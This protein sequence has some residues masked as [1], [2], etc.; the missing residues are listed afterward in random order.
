[1]K[2]IHEFFYRS[3]R[4]F[5]NIIVK[6]PKICM[7]AVIVS[8]SVW[9]IVDSAVFQS[10]GSYYDETMYGVMGLSD[11]FLNWF[12]W[13]VIGTACGLLTYVITKLV[14]SYKVLVIANLEKISKNI[15]KISLKSEKE[16]NTLQEKSQSNR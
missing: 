8:F 9:G 3:Y 1:M 10:E 4:S 11:G 5:F 6:W 13:A 15:E 16:K 12:V 7:I 14:V 2:D